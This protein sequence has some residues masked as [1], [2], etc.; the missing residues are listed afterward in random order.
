VKDAGE[1]MEILEAYDLVG[2]ADL[3]EVGPVV[4]DVPEEALDVGLVGRGPRTAGV[5]RHRVQGHELSGGARDHLRP[6]VGH[7]EQH[8]QQ[9]VGVGRDHPRFDLGEQPLD[10]ERSGVE[11]LDVDRLA[12]AVSHE[13]GFRPTCERPGP[14]SPARPGPRA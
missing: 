11:G 13:Q 3:F 5:H 4:L 12:A 6:V 7:G 8:R 1:I 10:L 14:R 9:L 2:E